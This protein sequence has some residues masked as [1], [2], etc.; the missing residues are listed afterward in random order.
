MIEFSG[1]DAGASGIGAFI[2][3]VARDN[4][5]RMDMRFGTGMAGNATEKIRIDQAGRLLLGVTS[6]VN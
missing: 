6:H 5:G 1:N 4:N 2:D 3:V